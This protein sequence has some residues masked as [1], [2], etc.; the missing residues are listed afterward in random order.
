MKCSADKLFTPVYL[1]VD[2]AMQWPRQEEAFYLLSAGGLFLCRNHRF[3]RSCVPAPE[4]PAELAAQKPFLYV[5]YPKVPQGLLE[6]IVGFFDLVGQELGSEA[7]VLLVWDSQANA[8]LPI[9]PEQVGTVSRSYYGEPYPIDLHYEIPALPPHQMLIGDIHSHVDGPAYASYTDKQDERHRP[10]LHLVVGRIRDEPP[11]F[12]CEVIVDGFRFP[13][14]NLDLIR[15]GYRQRRCHEVP[16]QWLNKV[17]AKPWSWSQNGGHAYT[18]LP[19][20]TPDSRLPLD[21]ET[22]PERGKNE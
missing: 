11:E 12:H 3:F 15:Q 20:S 7:A 14:R 6:R 4:P 2:Q 5:S 13:V 18:I 17:T 19:S 9:V 1:K 8:L 22:E 16:R 21:V 10:G